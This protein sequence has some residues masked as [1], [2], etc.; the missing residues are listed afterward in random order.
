MKE[1]KKTFF[2]TEEYSVFRRFRQAKFAY[3]GF[4]FK[5][6]PIFA[7]ASAASKNGARFKSGQS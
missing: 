4:N 2:Q 6:E 5:L 3:G 1:E 7:T